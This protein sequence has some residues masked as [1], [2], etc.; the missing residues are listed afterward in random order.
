MSKKQKTYDKPMKGESAKSF[1]KYKIYDKLSP[2]VRSIKKVAETILE[3]EGMSKSDKNYE[4]RLKK[5]ISSLENLSARWFWEER[6]LMHDADE[7]LKEAEEH[8]QE[9]KEVNNQ[10]IE[11]FKMIINSCE[12]KLIEINESLPVKSDG[13]SY[14][15]VTLIKIT[16]EIAITLKIANEQIRLCFGLPTDNTKVYHEANVNKHISVG[17]TDTL[18][19]I[20]EVDEELAD[21]YEP[22]T[23]HSNT[24]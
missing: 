20:R 9:Y 3:N 19:M 5:L 22:N 21:L 18:E 10:L 12:K 14:S 24:S 4:N 6:S 8:K 16:Y 13:S 17:S 23:E 2:D 7:L 1:K 15:I 11:C